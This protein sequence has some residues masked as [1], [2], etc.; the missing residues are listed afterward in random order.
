MNDWQVPTVVTTSSQDNQSTMGPDPDEITLGPDRPLRTRRRLGRFV[1]PALFV[2]LNGVVLVAVH[3]SGG[4]GES[5]VAPPTAPPP[6]ASA[7]MGA[8]PRA[9]HRLVAPQ[10]AVRGERITV[11]AYRT[12]RLCG[13][14]EL[15][16]DGKPTVYGLRAYAGRPSFDYVEML[17]TMNVPRSARPGSHVIEL[18]G[19]EQGDSAAALCGDVCEHQAQLASTTISINRISSRPLDSMQSAAGRYVRV[20]R[21]AKPS[22]C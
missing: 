22:G 13:P 17:M 9:D 4:A 20:G 21:A 10:T 15:R 14:P 3:V 12:R 5:A 8:S 18:Y 2:A 6:A 19:R 11:V 1:E 7:G 16:F